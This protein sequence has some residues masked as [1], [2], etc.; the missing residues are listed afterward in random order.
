[1]GVEE[2][3]LLDV[4]FVQRHVVHVLGCNVPVPS[5]SGRWIA[6]C[7]VLTEQAE[8]RAV[9]IPDHDRRNKWADELIRCCS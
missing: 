2:G 3:L 6:H 5:A 8:Q 7:D 4:V 1:M 9:G